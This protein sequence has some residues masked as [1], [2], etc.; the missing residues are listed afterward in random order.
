MRAAEWGSGSVCAAAIQ[1]RENP[2]GVICHRPSPRGCLAHY[3]KSLKADM[4]QRRWPL[5]EGPISLASVT[6]EYDHA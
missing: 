4:I 3:R 1:P 6:E 5:R 2:V